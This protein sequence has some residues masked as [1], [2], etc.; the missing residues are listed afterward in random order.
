MLFRSRATIELAIPRI[1]SDISSLKQRREELID[2]HDFQPSFINFALLIFGP[3]IL[4]L[5]LLSAVREGQFASLLGGLLITIFGIWWF[6]GYRRTKNKKDKLL[7]EL[8]IP[9]DKELSEL[10]EELRKY[11]DS[12]SSRKD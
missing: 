7:E 10:D 9:I 2:E 5:G 12:V 1:E 6:A 11:R 3:M 4:S 8:L